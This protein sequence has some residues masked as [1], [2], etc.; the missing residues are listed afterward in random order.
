MTIFFDKISISLRFFA[1][2][3]MTICFLAQFM[4]FALIW[5]PLNICLGFQ[6]QILDH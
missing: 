5:A 3:L 4:M 2:L 6:G 1:T